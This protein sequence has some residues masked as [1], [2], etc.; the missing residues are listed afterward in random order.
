MQRYGLT[1]EGSGRLSFCRIQQAVHPLAAAGAC[2]VDA[3]DIGRWGVW[4]IAEPAHASSMFTYP[5]AA[6]QCGRKRAL[7]ATEYGETRAAA[8]PLAGELGSALDAA[9][10]RQYPCRMFARLLCLLLMLTLATGA[11]AGCCPSVAGD[12]SAAERAHVG[13]A[14]C[15]HTQADAAADLGEMSD[16]EHCQHCRVPVPPVEFSRIASAISPARV[17]ALQ[18]RAVDTRMPSPLLRPPIS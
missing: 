16:C 15:P 13:M 8:K 17:L 3:W 14:D 12:L 4:A 2:P 11:A 18:T 9:G 7:A 5:R 1:S 10:A 6:A